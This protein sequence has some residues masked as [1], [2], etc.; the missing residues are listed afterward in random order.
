MIDQFLGT[1]P[2]MNTLTGEPLPPP[3][4]VSVAI[5]NGS[6]DSAAGQNAEAGL[7]TLHGDEPAAAEPP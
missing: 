5:E 7:K 6:G 1:N 4:S 2:K 3:S